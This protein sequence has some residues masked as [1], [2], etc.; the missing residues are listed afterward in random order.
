MK[1]RTSHAFPCIL[2]PIYRG[3]K[4]RA[5]RGFS[6]IEV[7]VA[8]VILAFGML[9]AVGMQAFSI[10]ANRDARLEAQAAAFATELAEMM[11]GNKVIAVKPNS[12]DNPYL[13]AST[14]M[15]SP[16]YCLSV[17]NA[18]T[19]CTSTTDVA[20]AEM[21]DWL[22]RVAA[23]LPGAK[24]R[25]CFDEAPYDA[26]SGLAKWDCSAAATNGIVFIKI[27]W[28][29][30]STDKSASGDAALEK[31]DTHPP[32]VIIPVTGGITT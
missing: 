13:V 17:S 20:R 21:T 19:G 16:S 26:Q 5:A 31:A 11:R 18:A 32:L 12:A 4:N 30:A 24:V 22:A 23:E 7:L 25:V 1:N 3:V 28:T 9:G 10:Q 27:G 2:I 8:I 14:T 6:L 29:R 15:A